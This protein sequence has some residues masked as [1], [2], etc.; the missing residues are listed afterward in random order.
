MKKALWTTLPN[1]KPLLA[2]RKVKASQIKRRA[3]K[4][5]I[6]K[7]SK[8]MAKRLRVYYKERQKFLCQYTVCAVDTSGCTGCSQDVHHQKGRGKY[9]LD[10][11]T[12]IPVC[13]VC[14]RY[15][16]DRPTWSYAEGWLEKR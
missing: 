6:R 14:H 13:R 8:A 3:S 15:I 7:Q 10:K 2:D 12:W 5:P 1:H 11:S 16:H 4:Q 9:L